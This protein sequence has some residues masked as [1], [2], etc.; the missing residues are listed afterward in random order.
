MGR[1]RRDGEQVWEVWE[2]WEEG[3]GQREPWSSVAEFC[4]FFGRRIIRIA[5]TITV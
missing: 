5:D 2:V 1:M 4:N 3:G